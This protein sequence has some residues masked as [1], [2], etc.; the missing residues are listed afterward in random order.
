VFTKVLVAIDGSQHA[1]AALHEAADIAHSQHASL[2]VMTAYDTIFPSLASMG[3]PVSQEM[4][5]QFTAAHVEKAQAVLTE[6]VSALPEGLSAETMM[7]EGQ[8]ARMILQQAAEGRHD[9]IVVGSRGHG[10][11]TS[12]LLGSVSHNVLHHSRVPVL[13]VHLLEADRG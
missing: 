6:A 4:Y 1:H 3:V 2:M 7:V 10:D 5:D 9:L 8:P 12:M 13:I 11:A